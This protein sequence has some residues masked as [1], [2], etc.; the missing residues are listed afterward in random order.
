MSLIKLGETD[1]KLAILLVGG[2]EVSLLR[3]HASVSG[4]N[5]QG[6]NLSLILQVVSNDSVVGSDR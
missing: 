2:L 5:L 1:M 6:W 3:N 4:T